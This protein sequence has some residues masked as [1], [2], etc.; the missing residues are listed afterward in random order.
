[1]NDLVRSNVPTPASIANDLETAWVAMREHIPEGERAVIAGLLS[2]SSTN[3]KAM[4]ELKADDHGRIRPTNMGELLLLAH[5][6]I[7]AGLAPYSY[8]NMPERVVIGLLKAMEIGVEPI[9]GLGNIMIVNNRPSVW[10]DLAQALVERSGQI[11]KQVKTEIGKAP[12]P[13]E[14]L[15][16]WSNDYGW[17]VETWRVGQSEPYIGQY[18]VADAKRAKSWMN[19]KK[20]PWITD[21]SRMLFNRAR[22]FSLR[23]GFSDCLFGMGIVEEQRDFE[24]ETAKLARP[25]LSLPSP[26]DD[27]EPVTAEDAAA[28]LPD[29]GDQTE[30][31][32]GETDAPPAAAS[33]E[34]GDDK[35]PL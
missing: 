9:S 23:D 3:I 21:P 15:L 20:S 5:T 1:M 18:T 17:R 10:G 14:E 12:A 19:T 29:Y 16:N 26:A 33:D 2:R 11:A 4:F 22:A 6:L 30:I 27:D 32:L 24:S 8:D 13:G 25:A 34:P 28:K 35:L 31:K 7:S